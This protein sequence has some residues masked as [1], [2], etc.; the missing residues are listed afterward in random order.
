MWNSICFTGLPHWIHSEP[1][2]LIQNN[3][4]KCFFRYQHTKPLTPC[5][6]VKNNEGLTVLLE[7]NLRA[8]TEGQFAVFYKDS[9]C[10]GSAKI[11]NICQNLHY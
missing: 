2:E 4:L 1:Q 3:V 9:E 7:N 5:K 10:M 8:I 11:T 6:I